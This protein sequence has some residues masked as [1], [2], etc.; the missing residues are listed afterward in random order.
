MSSER[1]NAIIIGLLFILA[2]AMGVISVG[3]FGSLIASENYLIKMSE[4]ANIVQISTFL[5]LVMVFAIVAIAVVLYPILKRESETLAIGFLSARIIEGI[6]IAMSTIAWTAMSTLGAEFLLAG[7]PDGAYFQTLGAL[8]QNAST[9][10]FTFGAEIAFSISAIILNYIFMRAKI[11]P[12]FISVWG[13]IGGFLL[14]ILGIMK[15]IGLPVSAVEIAFTAPIALNEM[16]LA[17]WLIVK[18]FNLPMMQE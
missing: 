9:L 17:I 5:I 6:I 4:S 10:S 12:M 18:G 7:Q 1:K 16:V 11:I 3:L 2:T 13:F 15:I 14:L 8:L